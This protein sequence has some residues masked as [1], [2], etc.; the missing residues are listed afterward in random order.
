MRG[1][2]RHSCGN[3]PEPRLHCTYCTLQHSAGHDCRGRATCHRMRAAQSTLLARGRV[4]VTPGVRASARPAYD[5]VRPVC[6]P[7][8]PVYEAAQPAHEAVG[9]AGRLACQLH[10]V[11]PHAVSTLARFCSRVKGEDLVACSTRCLEQGQRVQVWLGVWCLSLATNYIQRCAILRCE[12][13]SG[14]RPS[15]ELCG[16]LAVGHGTGRIADEPQ[17]HLHERHETE[18]A[19]GA[20]VHRSEPNTSIPRGGARFRRMGRFSS[21]P[22]PKS[23]GVSR[24]SGGGGGGRQK[25]SVVMP[26]G[27]SSC[28]ARLQKQ[29]HSL[30]ALREQCCR[31]SSSSVTGGAEEIIATA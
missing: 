5:A 4:G 29:P 30:W 18:R 7:V 26:V 22:D 13:G 6:R 21:V 2:V 24:G 27:N 15:T 12:S 1:A 17:A 10:A 20:D 9:P 16:S 3:N 8:R 25:S 14:F 31:W 19:A 23:R 28:S 11:K